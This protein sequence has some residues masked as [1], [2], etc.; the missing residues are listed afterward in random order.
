MQ[1]FLMY[2]FNFNKTLV[3]KMLKELQPLLGGMFVED[4][5]GHLEDIEDLMEEDIDV[6]EEI[7]VKNIPISMKN[8]A[9]MIL[10]VSFMS[11]KKC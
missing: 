7:Q 4:H 1:Y 11:Y 3:P 5:F 10:L 9:C 8:L 2:F 6:H